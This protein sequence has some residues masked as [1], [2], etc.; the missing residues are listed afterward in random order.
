MCG[1]DIKT[2]IVINNVK[3]TRA[4]AMWHKNDE[5]NV[6]QCVVCHKYRVDGYTGYDATHVLLQ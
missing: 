5:C 1:C 6:A 2:S 4:G 3:G